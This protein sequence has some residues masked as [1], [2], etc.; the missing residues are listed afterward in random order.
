MFE[1]LKTE[2]CYEADRLTIE[3]DK[4]LA[5]LMETAGKKI[6]DSIKTKFNPCNVLVLCGPGNN[7][8]DAF[9]IARYLKEYNF[10]I[11]IQTLADKQNNEV[12]QNNR[13]LY[14][15]NC[16]KDECKK[17]VIE[18][19]DTES[20]DWADIIVDGIFGAGLD[21][22]LND[23][24]FSLID[25][26]EATQKEKSK[27]KKTIIS[28]DLPT[29]INGNNGLVM[30]KA[31]KADYT[32]TFFRKKPAHLILPGKE[33]CGKVI[34]LDIGIPS[35]V[36]KDIKDVNTQENHKELWKDYIRK[37]K[38][39]D[40]KYTRGLVT[41]NSGNMHGATVLAARSARK[42]G[43][44]FI[45]ILT[46][47]KNHDIIANHCVGEVLRTVD[48]RARFKALL[49]EPTRKTFLIGCGNGINVITRERVL[50]VLDAG[51]NII[52]D[53]DAISVFRENPKE[54]F[55][56]IKEN[57]EMGGSC[58]LTPHMGEFSRVFKYDKNDKIQSVFGA[59]KE[60][61]AVVLLKGNDTIIASAQRN[62]IVINN[63]AMPNLATAGTGDSLSGITSALVSQGT[64]VFEAACAGTWIHG[65]CSRNIGFGLIAEDIAR[66]I[67]RV[68][69]KLFKG[70]K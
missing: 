18:F 19:G 46:S 24:V 50:N 21:K 54:L 58:L 1:V 55:R 51:K 4:S 68:M 39:S 10:N 52:I 17:E 31:I 60:S 23:P 41:I 40:N 2:Q 32:Y 8:G 45:E 20:V 38:I 36:L 48:N 53:A 6:A 29:G 30:L 61:G 42:T 59:S 62:K 34:V 69:K 44:G 43:A 37:Q 9:V 70:S 22:D 7:G 65:E 35:K 12:A 26:I 16:K 67:P 33:N 14:E 11:K 25:Y 66:E 28:I 56:A 13:E 5:Q 47:T 27:K 3:S 63:N 15:K 49:E 64:P 57:N